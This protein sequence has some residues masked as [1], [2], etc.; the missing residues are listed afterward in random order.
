MELTGAKKLALQIVMRESAH[1]AFGKV[2]LAPVKQVNKIPKGLAFEYKV[3]PS[4][5]RIQKSQPVISNAAVMA[6]FDELSTYA[7]FVYDKTTRGGVSVHLNSE[8]IHPAPVNEEVVIITKADKIGKSL[9]YCSMEMRNVKGDLLARGKHIKYMPMG[10]IWD[11]LGHPLILPWVIFFY[12]K[13][14][15]GKFSTPLD[16]VVFTPRTDV[17]DSHEGIAQVFENMSVEKSDILPAENAPERVYKINVKPQFK[18]RFGSF[19]GGAAAIAIEEACESY[20]NEFKF[21]QQHDEQKRVYLEKMEV[22]YLATMKGELEIH[23]SLAEAP[24][25]S[26][27]VILQGSIVSAKTKQ[28]CVEFV[29]SCTKG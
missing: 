11:V 25:H 16:N 3:P 1:R 27:E 2:L 4:L 12:D 28:V 22:R 24:F 7:C 6:I 19:H 14:Y 17:V 8:L 18:N 13:F 23:L 26:N 20:L 29:G 9:A 10:W 5:C 15:K 21:K